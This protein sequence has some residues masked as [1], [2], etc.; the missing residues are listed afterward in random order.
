MSEDP[1]P[2]TENPQYRHIPLPQAVSKSKRLIPPARPEPPS[3]INSERK[4][5]RPRFVYLCPQIDQ[6]R[7]CIGI[8]IVRVVK[9]IEEISSESHLDVF[10]EVDMLQNRQVDIPGSRTHEV[11]S[12][13]WPVVSRQYVRVPDC[14]IVEFDRDSVVEIGPVRANGSLEAILRDKVRH[15]SAITPFATGRAYVTGK[16][17]DLILSK[18]LDFGTVARTD[19]EIA[20]DSPACANRS[21]ETT[22]PVADERNLPATDNLIERARDVCTKSFATPK[23]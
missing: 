18:D 16:P 11:V 7:G 9:E 3:P 21:I 15:G 1:K 8:G 6:S 4:L 10:S 12:G 17:E 2:S 22:S 13:K 5:D 20:E 19:E 14:S 23:G